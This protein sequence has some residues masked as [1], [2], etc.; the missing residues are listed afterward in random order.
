MARKPVDA[1]VAD[2]AQQSSSAAS[3]SPRRRAPSPST[4]R[5]ESATESSFCVSYFPQRATLGVSECAQLVRPFALPVAVRGPVDFLPFSGSPRS[6]FRLPGSFRLPGRLSSVVIAAMRS[7]VFAGRVVAEGDPA[8]FALVV[9]EV[10]LGRL[11]Q[12]AT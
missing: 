12:V 5:G 1:K 7:R 10:R 8:Q 4:H 3:R 6:A 11:P 9:G 2:D